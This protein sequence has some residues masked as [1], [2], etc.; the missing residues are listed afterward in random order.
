MIN[1]TIT[2]KNTGS[3]I[4]NDVVYSETFDINISN[5]FTFII[6]PKYNFWRFGIRLSK[7]PK[8]EFFHPDNRYKQPEFNKYKDL[9]IGEGDWEQNSNRWTNQYKFYLAQY[10]F[11]TPQKRVL[12]KYE[13]H[14]KDPIKWQIKFDNTKKSIKTIFNTNEFTFPID[15]YSYFQIFAWADKTDF[16]IDFSINIGTTVVLENIK[17][18]TE[19]YIEL[20]SNINITDKSDGVIG[21]KAQSRIVSNLLENFK[22]DT[23]MMFGL[24]GKWGRGKTFF[25][26]EIKSNLSD[27]KNFI[28][29]EFHAWKYQ[30]TPASWAYL[31][32]TISE[33]FIK[34]PKHWL[35]IRGKNIL[36]KK[37]LALNIQ[38]KGRWSIIRFLI[39]LCLTIAWSFM[40]SLDNKIYFIKYILTTF[41]I[42]YI[43]GFITLYSTHLPRA[44]TL[45]KQYGNI[46]TY[47]NILGLQSEIQTELK[48]ILK[49]WFKTNEDRKILL[50]VDDIDRCSEEKIIQIID[51]FRVMLEDNEIYKRMIVVAAIDERVLMRAIKLKYKD[52]I[53]FNSKN[54]TG[55]NLSSLSRE[56]MDKLFISGIKLAALNENEKIEVF[57][58]FTLNKQLV[59]SI[60]TFKINK[61]EPRTIEINL[62]DSI[63]ITDEIQTD[64]KLNEKNIVPDNI[65]PELEEFEYDIL[66]STLINY[67]N[68]TPRSIRIYY[69][70]YLLAKKII[71]EVA[72]DKTRQEWNNLPKPDKEILPLLILYYSTI[73]DT[74]QFEIDKELYN[75]QDSN[76][77]NCDL[78]QTTFIIKKSLFCD[79]L[80]IIEMVV[81]Y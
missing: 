49:S 52:L 50:F 61:K 36:N 11:D 34:E 67:K 63:Q 1:K 10:N 45:L 40:F 48:L 30:D 53:N 19:K 42:S 76:T 23:G 9:H 54:E 73:K 12:S 46:K 2:L 37:V 29:I 64:F 8:I 79:I 22:N 5:D 60:A 55:M 51:S 17:S 74:S 65:T 43:I 70:R 72:Q 44:K 58:S 47:K 80:N 21:V 39:L 66:K 24:F 33:V 7:S 71:Q 35:K 75:K 59:K 6:K 16:E 3:E 41:S 31:Y 78:F 69:F 32:E 25:W 28:P 81:P 20:S 26:N 4:Y 62:S 14:S 38:K 27:N 77:I 57:N 13:D 15:D 68:A 18:I 56:Y